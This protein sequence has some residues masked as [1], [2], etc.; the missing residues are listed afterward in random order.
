VSQYLLIPSHFRHSF[1]R[2]SNVLPMLLNLQ[3]KNL[4]NS[5]LKNTDRTATLI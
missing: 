3:R 5:L 4:T 2:S 1:Q